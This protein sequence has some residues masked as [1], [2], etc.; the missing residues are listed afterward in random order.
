MDRR[1]IPIVNWVSSFA[2]AIGLASILIVI[3]VMNGFE[4]EIYKNILKSQP[5]LVL[6]NTSD[7]QSDKLRCED[8]DLTNL[9]KCRSFSQMNAVVESNSVIQVAVIRSY[10]DT[11]APPI[12]IGS[13]EIIIDASLASLLGVGYQDLLSIRIPVIKNNALSLAR[14]GSFRVSQIQTSKE[15]ESNT[16]EIVM[17][18]M[19]F[20][21]LSTEK[22]AEHNLI[23]WLE[24]PF[25]VQS[26]ATDIKEII[27]QS[28]YEMS[29]WFELNEN[30]FKAIVIE[31]AVMTG[32]L[33]FVVLIAIFNVMVMISMTI[34][35]K[36]GDIAI[37][38]SLGY[39]QSDVTQV[40]L[41]QGCVANI[42]GVLGGIIISLLVLYNLNHIEVISRNIFN[43]DFFPPG[44]YI[45]D[46]MPFIIKPHQFIWISLMTILMG[47]LASYLPSRITSKYTVPKLMR[48]YRS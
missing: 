8:F 26:L 1:Y 31:K 16:T 29:D 14:G 7:N 47:L 41:I 44:L 46:S 18:A 10:V 30:L 36:K 28:E 27:G 24:D 6:K 40:F 42:L 12:A 22:G 3:S 4:E 23:L 17:N 2:I 15:M 35:N 21:N 38:K 43:F 34:E 19:A 11:G 20:K 45:L 33:F 13:N 25:N 9:V 37:L 39:N 32:L 48:L 5:H